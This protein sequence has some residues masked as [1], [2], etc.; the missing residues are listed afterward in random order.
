MSEWTR[1]PIRGD[2][3]SIEDGL[4]T[5]ASPGQMRARVLAAGVTP[6]GKPLLLDVIGERTHRIHVNVPNS[7]GL[8]L[9]EGVSDGE[10]AAVREYI[11]VDRMK[12]VTV[13]FGDT[14]GTFSVRAPVDESGD[15]TVW[16]SPLLD[17]EEDARA[18]GL[19]QDGARLYVRAWQAFR[20]WKRMDAPNQLVVPELTSNAPLLTGSTETSV[21]VAGAIGKPGKTAKLSIWQL[22]D[23]RAV[24]GN[25]RGRWHQMSIVES[26]DDFSDVASWE[27]GFWVAGNEGDQPVVYDF[28]SANGS[29]LAVPSTRLDP[30]RPVT[31]IA[32]EPIGHTPLILATQSVEGPTV[33]VE[34]HGSW[35][36]I[37]GPEGTLS[38]AQVVGNQLYLVVNG[39][40]WHRTLVAKAEPSNSV[41]AGSNDIRRTAV[42]PA[43]QRALRQLL[44]TVAL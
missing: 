39:D 11:D 2:V 30:S 9:A 43:A 13:W 42:V 36:R 15:P 7:S 1:L 14:Y 27:I 31:Y 6:Q 22:G 26:A 21:V 12:P 35:T 38:D 23:G 17:G 20:S 33:W 16:L 18:V 44:S 40:L 25:G 32:Q 28:D 29:T 37:P 24:N 8:G 19:V 41:T 34:N 10:T 4:Y 5:A 3:R